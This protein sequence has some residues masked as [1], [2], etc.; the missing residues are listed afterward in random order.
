M[1]VCVCVCVCVCAP[2]RRRARRRPSASRPPARLISNN[3]TTTTNN[4]NNININTNSFNHKDTK[5]SNNISLTT[6]RISYII[7]RPLMIMTMLMVNNVL[8]QHC[9]RLRQRLFLLRQK[10][11]HADV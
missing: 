6:I 5:H 10:P 7:I 9:V 8:N 11:E 4:N 1:H 2:P 3:N